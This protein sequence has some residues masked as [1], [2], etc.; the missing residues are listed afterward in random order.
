MPS[1]SLQTRTP[2]KRRPKRYTEE[3]REEHRLYVVARLTVWKRDQGTCQFFRYADRYPS[4]L[5]LPVGCD[6]DLDPHHVFDQQHYPE[7]K[8]DPEAML[9][10]CR[11]HHSF[12]HAHRSLSTEAGLL[13]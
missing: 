12:T 7:R 9:T 8:T 11:Q 13:R 3:E 4:H 1:S 2:L 6:G 10:L 5:R